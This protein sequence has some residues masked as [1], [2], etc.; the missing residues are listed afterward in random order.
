MCIHINAVNLGQLD[1]PGLV[2]AFRGTLYNRVR[3]IMTP[4]NYNGN[5]FMFRNDLSKLFDLFIDGVNGVTICFDFFF[6]AV[7]RSFYQVLKIAEIEMPRDQQ[8]VST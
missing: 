6:G 1:E 3:I 7:R 4:S 2:P 5:F 8:V